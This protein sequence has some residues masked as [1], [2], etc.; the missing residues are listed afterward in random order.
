MADVTTIHNQLKKLNIDHDWMHFYKGNLS[1]IVLLCFFNL[2]IT[3]YKNLLV[4]MDLSRFVSL[5]LLA[6]LIY[7]FNCCENF[8]MF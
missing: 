3:I 2:L 1:D 7:R 8:S 5:G 6:L 4:Q